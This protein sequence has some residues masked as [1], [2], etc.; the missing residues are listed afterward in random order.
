M[1][2]VRRGDGGPPTWVRRYRRLLAGLDTVA[3]LATGWGVTVIR[4][5][6]L[7]TPA[8]GNRVPYIVLVTAAAPVWP[9]LLA[10]AR[11]YDPR[12]LG[13]GRDEFRR[14]AIAGSRLLLAVAVASYASKTGVGRSLLLLGVP[15]LVVTTVA[16]RG[17]ARV[18]L[19]RIRVGGGACYRVLVVGGEPAV[20][21][22]VTH[23]RRTPHAGLVPVGCVLA[24]SPS[25]AVAGV[26]VWDSGG[27][28]GTGRD[29]LDTVTAAVTSRTDIDMVV[30]AGDGTVDP[31]GVR[32]LGW[33]LEGSRVGLFL[34][35]GL[36]DMVVPRLT[37][38]P[39]GDMVLLHIAAAVLSG[40]RRTVKTV[41]DVV[42]AAVGLVFAAPILA[43]CAV[44]IR[45]DSPG[46]VIFRQT[47]VGEGGRL[48]TVYK[49]RS[50]TVDAPARRAEVEP[51][52]EV[53]GG[54]LF[55]MR[56]DPRLTRVGRVLRRFS[57]DELP[58]LVNVCRG[59]MSLVGPRP[60]LPSEVARY[61]PDA[62]RRLLVR[63]GLT[64]LWQVSGRADLP[65]E[66]AVTLDLHYVANWSPLLD[67]AILART[68]RAVVA[69]R[70]AY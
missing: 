61:S 46:P 30:V 47:R 27:P 53:I 34:A 1:S 39:V 42:F 35:P 49:L 59:Q 8:A 11:A 17:V 18:G 52:N 66:Q 25:P 21:G 15:A 43:L 26:P 37:V 31:D 12:L 62:R 45:L 44:A 40:P 38:T 14:V 24:G 13:N 51:G 29:V 64:G 9:V 20:R 57:L 5:G 69:G 22:L 68:V 36:A 33:A 58:Q 54:V 32:R 41:F 23:L 3:F 10:F 28:V 2:P 60:P 16:G 63:P 7:L 56:D 4:Y 67:V 50:M 48:F 6:G 65:W 19:N 70:G 55:K